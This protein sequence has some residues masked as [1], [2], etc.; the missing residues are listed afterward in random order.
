MSRRS[1]TRLPFIPISVMKRR[2]KV[3]KDQLEFNFQAPVLPLTEPVKEV[4][5]PQ[6]TISGTY[7]SISDRVVVL[8]PTNGG[9]KFLRKNT[10][11]QGHFMG[12]WMIGYTC[13]EKQPVSIENGISKFLHSDGSGKAFYL[14]PASS[15]RA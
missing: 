2:C 11:Q 1:T 10:I 5:I 6:A 8:E 15:Y 7:P 3:S 9:W 12:T 4:S 13:F 14:M